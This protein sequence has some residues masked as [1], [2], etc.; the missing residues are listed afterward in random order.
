M[1]TPASGADLTLDGVTVGYSGGG[2]IARRR[3]TTV[4]L[5]DLH[6]R[7]R[8]GRLTVLLGGNGSGKS[9]LLRSVAGLQPLLAGT[10]SLG[11]A[12]LDRLS[13]PER[14]ARVAVVLTE[15]FDPGLLR[16]ADVVD[17]G[18]YPHRRR[19]SAA[20]DSQAVH[21]ALAAVH[22]QDLARVPL[23]RMSDGQRQRVMIARA[24]AQ[25]PALLLLDEPTAF[26][27]APARLELLAVLQRIAA[28]RGI[29][30]VLSSHD[31]ELAVRS[32]HDAWLVGAPTSQ[33]V[34][35]PVTSGPVDRLSENGSIGAAF[36]T[37]AVAF[38]VTTGRFGLRPPAAD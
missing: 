38:D 14:A 20:V 8:A 23:V 3:A 21:E 19:G 24:L 27:D 9:T 7:A 33:G 4:I 11:D 34:P 1:S 13:P 30:V 16:G 5:A 15:S 35:R 36:D 10:V 32:G 18:R 2:P 26:L 31:V 12:R 29:P 6:L 25:E 37:D 22:A 17:L 28:G